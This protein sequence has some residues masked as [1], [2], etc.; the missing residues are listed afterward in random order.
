MAE[1]LRDRWPVL[2]DQIETALRS[3]EPALADR[4]GEL[5]VVKRCACPDESCQS[6]YTA[7]PPDGAYGE[8]HRNVVLEPPWAGFL[9]LDVVDDRI[10]Y[11]EVLDRPTLD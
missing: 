4:V 1:L 3:A 7:P 10:T 2:A 9:I 11:V 6:F 8:S 5:P